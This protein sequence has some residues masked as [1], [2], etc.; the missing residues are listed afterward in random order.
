M[1]TTRKSKINEN[2]L[3]SML[4]KE[5][6]KEVRKA[7]KEATANPTDMAKIEDFILSSPQFE[8]LSTSKLKAAIKDMH[9]EW[10]AVAK[11][12]KSIE[13]YFEEIEEMGGE[14]AFMENT[15]TEDA[16]EEVDGFDTSYDKIHD[17]LVN[18]QREMTKLF[19]DFKQNKI[20]KDQ[21]IAKR[22]ELQKKRD[23]LEK[24]L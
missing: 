24:Q 18:I 16:A 14:E 1:K 19:A 9:T 10:K 8:R 23:N 3:R 22:K 6:N 11:N 12:Y 5:I 21:Y 20:N 13:A 7:L 17:D 4:R 15:L 2:A